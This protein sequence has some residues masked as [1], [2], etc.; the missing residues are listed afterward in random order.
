MSETLQALPLEWTK[1]KRIYVK[2][3]KSWFKPGDKSTLKHGYYKTKIYKVW[4]EM[5]K[6]CANPNATGYENY[7][8]RGIS[9]CE[10]WGDFM[11]FLTD[12][13]KPEKGLLLDRINTNGNYEPENC[14]WVSSKEQNRNKRNSVY[15]E[16][17]GKTQCVSAW[18]EELG[19][20]PSA[21]RGR[22]NRGW[23]VEKAVLTPIRGH[24]KYELHK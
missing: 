8:G 21:I 22:L 3:N 6:R 11:T 10:R 14:R 2:P 9:V 7:G 12:M 18:A 13:G 23:D 4:I 17:S 15:L 24:K 5:R 20:D 19:V 1:K 16:V